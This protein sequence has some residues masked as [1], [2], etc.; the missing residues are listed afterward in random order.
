MSDCGATTKGV[1]AIVITK[2]VVAA[3][4]A[5]VGETRRRQD[6]GSGENDGAGDEFHDDDDDASGSV[7]CGRPALAGCGDI[8]SSGAMG[9]N[10]DVSLGTIAKAASCTLGLRVLSRGWT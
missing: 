3:G 9:F 6:N 8:L 10:E 4:L 1:A 2:E 5:V 7:V